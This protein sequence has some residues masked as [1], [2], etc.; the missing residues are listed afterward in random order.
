MEFMKLNIQLF[1]DGKIIIGTEIDNSGIEKGLKETESIAEREEKNIQETKERTKQAQEKIAEAQER[2]KQAQEETKKAEERIYEAKKETL[3]YEQDIQDIQEQNQAQEKQIVALEQNL[4][5]QEQIQNEL[6]QIGKSVNNITKKVVKWSLSV[7]G[8]QGAFSFIKSSMS[9]IAQND[10]QLATDLQYMKTVLAYAI[11]PIVRVIVNLFKE[12][13]YW[14]GAIIKVTTGID[15]F[16]NTNKSLQNANKGAKELKKQLTG[17]DEMNV[18]SDTSGGGGGTVSPSL[19][20]SNAE[21]YEKIIK[22]I[23]NQWKQIGDELKY[24]T[25]DVSFNEWVDSFN[26]W[27]LS[28]YGLTTYFYGLWEVVDGFFE[29]IKG[30]IDVAKGIITGDKE[31]IYK[32]IVEMLDGL[33]KAIDGFFNLVIANIEIVVGTVFG[34]IV[35]TVKIIW[36]NI[37]SSFKLGLS[38]LSG[39]FTTLIEI[40]KAPFI[41]LWETAKTVFNSIINTVKGVFNVIKGIF[42]GDMKTVMNGFKQIFKSAFDAL[43]GIVK[44]PLNLVIEGINALIKGI[45][46]I[47]FDVPDWVPFIGGQKWGFNL[48]EIPKLAKGGIVNNPGPGVMMGSYIAGEKG[49]EAVIP[50]DDLTLDRLGEAFARHTQINASIPVYV[51][52]RQ[53]AR[54]LRKINAEDNFAFNN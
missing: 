18:L 23:K 31:L 17:F 29:F 8:I 16:A 22:D 44:A 36:E 38:I 32:G 12:L 25:K 51:G 15:I 42:T 40:L 43:W 35:D 10:Q 47:S 45:N 9:T 11:E 20:L 30:A 41:I 39:I 53:I 5:I 7:L 28:V 52:N 54:E 37:V 33:W 6:K 14:I 19:D 21:Q 1:A 50:L 48:K 49:P 27:A 13:V 4:A 26:E 2:T 46:K 34:L 24:A 3:K